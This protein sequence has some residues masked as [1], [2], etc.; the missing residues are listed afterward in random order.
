MERAGAGA[1]ARDHAAVHIVGYTIGNDMSS[2]DIEGENPLYLPQ[3][4]IYDGSCAL[5]PAVLIREDAA[6]ARHGDRAA[7][8]PR[9]N[10]GV[11]G[12]HHAGADAPHAGGAGRSSST[13]RRAS[14][15]AACC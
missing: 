4:K 5:G 6:A 10:H 8:H 13:G 7:D 1:R 12:R 2:R 3:A 9:R 14:R 15:R 11:R